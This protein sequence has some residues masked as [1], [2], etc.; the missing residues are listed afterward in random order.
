M[1]TATSCGSVNA[2]RS[3]NARISVLLSQLFVDTSAGGAATNVTAPVVETTCAAARLVAIVTMAP[4]TAAQQIK[5]LFIPAL[6]R[7]NL[8]EISAQVERQGNRRSA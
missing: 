2:C 1:S 3:A 6:Q 4:Q 8:S 7:R 5:C